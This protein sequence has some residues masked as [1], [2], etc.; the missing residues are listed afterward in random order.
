MLIGEI[1]GLY[2]AIVGLPS[3]FI[4]YFV[5]QQFISEVA[6]MSYVKEEVNLEPSVA[7]DRLRDR[8]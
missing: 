1:G 7:E 5:Q 2:G 3:I 6:K 4:S 8:I